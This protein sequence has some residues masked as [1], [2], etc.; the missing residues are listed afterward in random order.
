[1]QVNPEQSPKDE[2]NT[3]MHKREYQKL[4]RAPADSIL[5]ACAD[6]MVHAV[7]PGPPRTTIDRRRP[8]WFGCN[9]GIWEGGERNRTKN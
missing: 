9:L 3:E 1:M 4:K 7:S 5:T 8:N 2:R 6:E